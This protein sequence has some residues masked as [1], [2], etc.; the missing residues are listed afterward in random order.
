MQRCDLAVHRGTRHALPLADVH[1]IGFEQPDVPVDARAL[2]KPAVS[3]AGVDAQNDV[4]LRAVGEEIR[5][6]EAERDIAIVAAADEAA[7]D[8]NQ[9]IAEGAVEL[10]PDAAANIA[11]GDLEFAP[12]PLHAGF[13][14]AAP[15][16]LV[17]M[18][19]RRII[20]ASRIVVNERKLHCPVVR[21]MQRSPI[22]IVEVD[23]KSTR[24]N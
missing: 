8:E 20:S 3:E 22:G 6:I 13:G 9:K 15:Q 21:E 17:T 14:I 18:R 16:R 1:S 23:R 2:V 5:K 10:N 24:L 4:V 19:A 7:V 12:V 11:R